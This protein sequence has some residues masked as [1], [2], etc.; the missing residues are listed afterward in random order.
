MCFFHF[1]VFSAAIFHTEN[2]ICFVDVSSGSASRRKWA[3]LP[4]IVPTISREEVPVLFREEHVKHGFRMIHQPWSYYICSIFQL[5]NESM[6]VWTHLVASV[7]LTYKLVEFS[8]QIDFLGDCHSWPMLAGLLSS[9]ILYAFSSG[10]HCLQSKSELVHY[11]TFMF[12]YTGIGLYG[13]GSVVMHH[14]YCSEASFYE[15]VKNYY[16]PAGIL[17]AFLTTYCCTVA[18]MYY[19]RPYP[20]MRKIWQIVPVAGIYAVLVSPIIHR[21]VLCY[22]YGEVCTENLTYHLY[23]MFWFFLSG[24]FFASDIPQC[25][26]PGRFDHFFHSHQLFHF[27]IMMSSLHQM[28]ANFADLQ[29]RA[30]IFRARSSPTFLSSFGPLLLVLAADLGSILYFTGHIKTKMVKKKS[31]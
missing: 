20:P 21:L 5:H 11:V 13:L 18:K 16:L 12:D 15:V 19:T 30:F 22:V 4:S 8:S 17:L 7:I 9:I 24:L 3:L 31:L 26:L 14:W 25:W 10:A 6:N 1:I 29:S 23:H 2:V 28:D 27:A